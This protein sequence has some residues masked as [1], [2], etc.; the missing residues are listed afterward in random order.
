[1]EN[2]IVGIFVI[3]ALFLGLI[4]GAVIT[5]NETE[6]QTVYQDRI[7]E[8]TVEVPVEVVVDAPNQLELAVAEFMTAVENEEDEAGRDVDVLGDYY[9]DEVEVRSVED[10]YTVEYVDDKTKVYF[11]INLRLDDDDVRLKE[12]YDV[13]VVF[14][15]DED[16]RVTIL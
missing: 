4:G 14:E 7:V 12:T 3:L 6:V 5:P 9:F 10:D 2:T 8:K 15:D 1:M 13:K 11:S 16:T